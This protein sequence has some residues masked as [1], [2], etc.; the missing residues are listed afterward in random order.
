MEI[1]QPLWIQLLNESH[2]PVSEK[3]YLP[4]RATVASAF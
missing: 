2:V 1:P 3:V 4:N